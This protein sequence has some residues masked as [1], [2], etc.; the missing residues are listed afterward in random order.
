MW[1]YR[2]NLLLDEMG[3]PNH[4]GNFCD[5]PIIAD[6]K[7]FDIL[8]ESSFYYMGHFSRFIRPGSKRIACSRFTQN[9]ETTAFITLAGERVLVVLN[10]ND[11]DIKFALR[12]EKELADT[13]IPAHSIMTM[14]F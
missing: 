12:F 5:A 13:C 10:Q 4:V 2:L 1:L 14:I 7:T 11:A 9:L 3:G 6:T 8:Y